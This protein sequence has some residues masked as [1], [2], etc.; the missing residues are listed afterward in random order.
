MKKLSGCCYESPYRLY[1]L[2]SRTTLIFYELKITFLT[3][4]FILYIIKIYSHTIVKKYIMVTNH[5]IINLIFFYVI[6]FVV[7]QHVQTQQHSYKQFTI[8]PKLH[9]FR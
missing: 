3:Y 8:R 2:N 1:S 5:Q 6:V 9:A 7:F 4:I